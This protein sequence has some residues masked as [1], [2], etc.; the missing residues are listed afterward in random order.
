MEEDQII[1]RDFEDQWP[2]NCSV[3]DECDEVN[4]KEMQFEDMVVSKH[5]ICIGQDAAA[6]LINTIKSINTI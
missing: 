4:K 5:E 1:N 3:A 6:Q 2:S